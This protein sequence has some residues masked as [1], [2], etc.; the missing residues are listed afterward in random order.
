MWAVEMRTNPLSEDAEAAFKKKRYH[1]MRMIKST[2][3]AGSP[4]SAKMLKFTV[5]R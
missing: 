5:T 2:G 4:K 1:F 3:K